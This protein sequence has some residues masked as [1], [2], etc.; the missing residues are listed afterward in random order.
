MNDYIDTWVYDH[1]KEY[2]NTIIRTETVEYYG[3]DYLQILLTD[4][5][6]K[7]VVIKAS[8]TFYDIDEH[9]VRKAVKVY[10]AWMKD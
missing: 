10:T 6:G 5:M 2:G 4:I 3:V 7:P 1:L 9:M 8:D